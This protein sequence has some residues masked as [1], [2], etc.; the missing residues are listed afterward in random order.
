MTTAAPDTLTRTLYLLDDN[1][2]F[3]AT[4]KWW[5]SG[6]GYHVIDF[7]DAQT[8]IDALKALDADAIAHA[9]LLLDVRMPTMT[10]L[11]VHDVLIEAGITG[12]QAQ[13]SLPIVYMTGHG[14]VPLAVQ[15]MEK[16]AITFLEKPFQDSALESALARAFEIA[17]Q[18][19]QALRAAPVAPPVAA[20]L[21]SDAPP[22]AEYLRRRTSLSPR[23]QQVM[24]GVVEGK[25]SKTIARELDISTKTVE[26]HRSR[27]MAKMRA[28]SVVHLT[29]MALHQRVLD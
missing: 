1:D 20:P 26:L 9:C 10:G 25:I 23:E 7:Q 2:D 22:C 18:Q 13:P 17:S 6:A 14:D 21:A 27:V 28:E 3:R 12:A 15:A 4:A 29:R 8:A 11:Q 24:Q 19:Q 16:W 5:L